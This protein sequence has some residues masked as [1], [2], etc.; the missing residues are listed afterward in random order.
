MSVP[1]ESEK[2]MTSVTIPYFLYEAMARAYYNRAENADRPSAVWSSSM[3]SPV[4]LDN[5]HLDED[6]PSNWKPGGYALKER[7]QDAG[8]T[9]AS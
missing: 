4:V 9:D 6:F 8:Q 5:V 2:A 3:G 7:P 1:Q